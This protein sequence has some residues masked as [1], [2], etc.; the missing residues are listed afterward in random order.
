MLME[1][2]K[3]EELIAKKTISDQIIFYQIGPMTVRLIN[4]M[5]SLLARY[6]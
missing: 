1:L 3:K 2:P 4:S 6:I 5:E